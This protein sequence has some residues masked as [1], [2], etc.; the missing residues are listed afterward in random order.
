MHIEQ[1][2]SSIDVGRVNASL[3]NQKR[4]EKGYRDKNKQKDVKI[5]IRLLTFSEQTRTAFQN[6]R[7]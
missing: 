5:S 3:E 6:N 4:R 2:C 7:Y 1:L